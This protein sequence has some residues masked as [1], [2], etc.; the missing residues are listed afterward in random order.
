[1]DPPPHSSTIDIFNIIVKYLIFGVKWCL[2]KLSTL[3]ICLFIGIETCYRFCQ[4]QPK[5]SWA[6]IAI[7]SHSDPNTKTT[8]QGSI[9]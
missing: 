3:L 9:R 5:L 4:A 8:N 1:M 6:E 7:K 2:S